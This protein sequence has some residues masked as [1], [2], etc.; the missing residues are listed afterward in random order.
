MGDDDAKAV[1]AELEFCKTQL[2]DDNVRAD[3]LIAFTKK[4]PD[5]FSENYSGDNM[6]V[7]NQKAGGGGCVIL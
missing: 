4:D 2:E 5:P 1:K 7:S 3:A 6:W